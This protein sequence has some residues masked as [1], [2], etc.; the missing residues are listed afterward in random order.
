MVITETQKLIDI[1]ELI[2]LIILSFLYSNIQK[3]LGDF[4]LILIVLIIQ[5]PLIVTLI[6]KAIFFDTKPRSLF[7]IQRKV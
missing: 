3:N 7:L 5:V 1:I 4:R 2:N 6:V